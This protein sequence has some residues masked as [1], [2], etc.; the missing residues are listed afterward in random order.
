LGRKGL[1]TIKRAALKG[2]VDVPVYYDELSVQILHFLAKEIPV[3]PPPMITTLFF[4]SSE[5]LWILF[6]KIILFASPVVNHCL[7]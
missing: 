3:F 2:V 1:T 6:K 5:G 7:F 4:M